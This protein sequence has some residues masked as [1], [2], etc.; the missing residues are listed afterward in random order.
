MAVAFH[1]P[2]VGGAAI[3]VLRV[4]P[5]LEARGWRFVFWAPRPGPLEDELTSRGYDVAGEPRL[6]RYSREALSVPPGPLRRL[7]GVPGYLRRF[8]RWVADQDPALVHANTLI[9]I[10]EAIAA[11]TT[12]A[13]VLLYV[14]E[15]LPGGIRGAVAGRLIRAS[16]G[17]VV[18]N[19]SASV[20]AL[21][22]RGIRAHKVHYGIEVPPDPPAAAPSGSPL[23][24]GTLGTVSE[25]KGS[26][27]FLAVARMVREQLPDAEFRMIGPCPEGSERVWAEGIVAEARREGVRVGTITDAFAELREW[28]LLVLPT[29]SEPFGLVL[30]E[31]M[32]SRR[33]PVASRIDGPAE[34]VTPD[35]GILVD[36]DD[37]R[38]FADAVLELARDPARRH[39]MGQAGRARVESEF[40]LEHQ[41]ERVHQAYLE[42]AR[43]R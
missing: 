11:R 34:I 16:A 31:A 26:D 5:L 12:G 37:A 35:T 32:A 3:A 10:P 42:A 19:S 7:A 18:T 41:A 27:V 1:E 17:A 15:I 36:V 6:L 28:D 21:E 20:G 43:G 4:L 38:A 13:P 8:R 22:R 25:R 2:V 29:R 14:H 24:V 23:V 30:I 40:T 33:P 39:A 9:T